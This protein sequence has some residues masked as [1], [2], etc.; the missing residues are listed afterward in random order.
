MTSI[1][2]MDKDQADTAR[3]RLRKE[4]AA[5]DTQLREA[6]VQEVEHFRAQNRWDPLTKK[7]IPV[8]GTWHFWKGAD[9]TPD[10]RRELDNAFYSLG[11]GALLSIG[12]I[13]G[14][15]YTMQSAN[16]G[17]DA[18]E[19]RVDE[20]LATKNT[21]STTNV[22]LESSAA[23]NHTAQVAATVAAAV[24]GLDKLA[25]GLRDYRRACVKHAEAVA[26]LNKPEQSEERENL[27]AYRAELDAKLQKVAD[28]LTALAE[29]ARKEALAMT[30]KANN[31]KQR[32]KK[33]RTGQ[34][35]AIDMKN[36]R[37]SDMS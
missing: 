1:E 35:V 24:T 3:R 6:R 2:N 16:A 12:S 15:V 4:A 9:W 17:A 11:Y 18:G 7:P 32:K 27:E 29:Q 21:T 34:D 20:E 5:T 37:R 13:V 33:K 8:E 36:L 31:A 10:E 28:R 26:K 25:T 14:A 19:A 22:H 23:L 30:E